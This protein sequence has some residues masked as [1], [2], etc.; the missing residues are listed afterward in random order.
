MKRTY[1]L[2][3]V[4]LFFPLS[5][6]GCKEV[7]EK[8]EE[9][10]C[11][12]CILDLPLLDYHRDP[13]NALAKRLISVTLF[14]DA[15]ALLRFQKHGIVQN[16]MH[17]L[18]YNHH[19]EIGKKLGLVLGYRLVQ[20]GYKGK[21]DVIIPVPLHRHRKLERGYNQSAAFAQA[22]A[23]TLE[24]E[25]N[26]SLLVRI[27]KTKTQTR[28]NKTERWENLENAFQVEQP[29]KVF[30]KRILLVD[31]VVTTGATLEACA[32]ILVRYGPLNISAACMADVP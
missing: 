21:W 27:K 29:G 25:M 3:F 2:D 9:L 14:Q 7:L 5:C 6:M 31:D 11:T 16:L 30:G 10:L 19:P 22:L 15:F 18:K 23:N 20:A 28:K 26:E 12:R 8:G 4:R 13:E 17:E 1:L 24:A 32:R